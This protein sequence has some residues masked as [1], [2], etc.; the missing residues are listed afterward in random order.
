MSIVEDRVSKRLVVAVFD[1]GVAEVGD[2]G[3]DFIVF[4]GVW[5]P[6]GSILQRRFPLSLLSMICIYLFR[7]G[8]SAMT[9]RR[10]SVTVASGLLVRVN[11]LTW[12]SLFLLPACN[13]W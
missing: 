4:F 11:A 5:K 1:K 2:D 13:V 9:L 10:H 8:M 6:Y 3:G 12:W 7:S